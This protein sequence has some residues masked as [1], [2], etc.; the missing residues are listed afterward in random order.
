MAGT[1][2]LEVKGDEDSLA[3]IEAA[4]KAQGTESETAEVHGLDGGPDFWLLVA[5]IAATIIGAV[6][7]LVLGL[8]KNRKITSIKVNGAEIKGITEA[9]AER[10]L[11]AANHQPSSDMS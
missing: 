5:K 8:L 10:L 6:T 7:P 9:E 11:K 3:H 2:E 1:I 4:L